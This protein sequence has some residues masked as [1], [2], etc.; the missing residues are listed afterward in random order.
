MMNIMEAIE[1]TPSSASADKAT[2]PVDAEATTV[3]E[4]ENLA[5]T[6]QKSTDLYQMWLRRKM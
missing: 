2:I 1:H 6:L 4:A 5:T 3:A